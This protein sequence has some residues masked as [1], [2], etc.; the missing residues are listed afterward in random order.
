MPD[1]SP[2][3]AARLEKL[4]D[5]ALQL[6]V[7]R[8][9]RGTSM[10]AL[11]EAAGLSKVTLYSYFRDK[12]AAFAGVARRLAQRLQEACSAALQQDSTPAARVTA[13][14]QAKH[15]MVHDIV[16]SSVFASEILAQK[17]GVAR[18][19]IALDQQ[20]IGEI[21]SVL[22]DGALAR[23]IFNAATGIAENAGSRA[24]MQEDIARLVEG[25]VRP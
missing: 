12:D 15:A 19:F 2:L 6:F 4:L 14:L 17:Q 10:E 9:Y 11:A 5:A 16:R 22:G 23:L 18:I 21:A 24:E 25:L 3:K 8:G 7:T 13:A 1:L 20:I